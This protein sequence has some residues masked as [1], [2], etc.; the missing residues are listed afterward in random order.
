MKFMKE[1]AYEGVEIFDNDNVG[2]RVAEYSIV[3]M[4]NICKNWST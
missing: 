4:D 3:D 1:I 2:E